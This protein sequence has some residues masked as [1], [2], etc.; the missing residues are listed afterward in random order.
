MAAAA[1]APIRIRDEIENLGFFRNGVM[2][3]R[4]SGSPSASERNSGIEFPGFE[5][6]RADCPNL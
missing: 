2:Y 1:K 4:G 5:F 3:S 6:G